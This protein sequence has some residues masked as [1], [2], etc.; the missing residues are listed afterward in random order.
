MRNPRILAPLAVAAACLFGTTGCIKSTLLKGQIEGTRKASSAVDTL[1]DFEVA[2]AAAY[3]G[4]AQFEGMH[5]LAPDNTD[6][7]FM[8]TKGWAGA[9]FAFTE[10]EWEMHDD[11]KHKEMAEYHRLRAVAGYERA[12]EYG[13]ELLEKSGKKGFAEASKSDA[14]LRAWLKEHFTEKDDAANLFWLGY[15]WLAK[16]NANKEDSETVALL[17]VAVA[18]LERSVE[19]DETYNYASGLTALAAYHARTAQSELN[20][21]KPLFDKAMAHTQGKAL[22]QKFN[23]A[24]R[25]LCGK[26][27]R[28][29]YVKA[30]QEIVDAGDTLPEQRLTNSIAKRRARR[31][32]GK[33]RLDEARENCGFAD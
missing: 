8:L 28:E 7:L 19:L 29:G 21:A 30:L 25:Y 20:E 6:A 33:A 22:I 14:T 10:D 4:L 9:T 11:M 18:I 16:T 24:T 26:G 2:R 17:W 23:Y 31:Y 13:K 27:D 5:K 1:H 32:L 15:A 3:A 12:I